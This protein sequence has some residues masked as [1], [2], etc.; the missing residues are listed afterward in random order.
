M[1]RIRGDA[2]AATTPD[3]MV[4]VIGR[5]STRSLQRGA[6]MQ[7]REAPQEEAENLLKREPVGRKRAH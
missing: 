6:R 5:I 3:E 7:V 4:V 1:A 2:Q